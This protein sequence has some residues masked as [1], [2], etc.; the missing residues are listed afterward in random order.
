MPTPALVVPS[1]YLCGVK[2]KSSLNDSSFL[3]VKIWPTMS[4]AIPACK[5]EEG[6]DVDKNEGQ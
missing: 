6:G 2:S 4:V 5:F 3:S 1:T